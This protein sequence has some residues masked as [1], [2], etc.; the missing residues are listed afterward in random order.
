[1]RGRYCFIFT[2]PSAS[3][4]CGTGTSYKP[5]DEVRQNKNKLYKG[6]S[7]RKFLVFL[8]FFLYQNFVYAKCAEVPYSIQAKQAGVQVI[9]SLPAKFSDPANLP[10]PASVRAGAEYIRSM[11]AAMGP[12]VVREVLLNY[13]CRFDEV[14]DGD[15]TKSIDEKTALKSAFQDAVD[16]ITN[17]SATYFAVFAAQNFEQAQLVKPTLLNSPALQKEQLV[18]IAYLQASVNQISDNDFLI[19]NSYTAYVTANLKGVEATACGKY[20]RAAL[21]ENAS[22]VQ[23]LAASLR[24]MLMTY[25]SNTPSSV[26]SAKTML[27]GEAATAAMVAPPAKAENTGYLASCAI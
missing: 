7:M 11:Y 23:H 15:I 14:V 10:K 25:F 9:A 27:F 4:Y 6:I 1:M 3:M 24:G 22:V 18:P 26:R 17:T 2:Q 19:A 20:I 5:S 16:D 12:T 8:A 13:I 21:A